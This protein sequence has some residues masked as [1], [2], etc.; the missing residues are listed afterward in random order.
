MDSL[1]LFR[2]LRLSI[3]FNAFNIRRRN[4]NTG[5]WFH[6]ELSIPAGKLYLLNSI[7]NQ[8]R[9]PNFHDSYLIMNKPSFR[10]HLLVPFLM[11]GLLTACQNSTEVSKESS[12]EAPI[13]SVSYG[14]GY[15][16]GQSIA[17]EG[18]D[19]FNYQN[20]IAGMQTAVDEEEPVMDETEMQETLQQFQVQLQQQQE[21]SRAEAAARN[22][23][24]SAA[25][26]EENGARDE[27]DVTESGLQYEV[28]EAGD[29]DTPEAQST[30]RVH[31]SGTLLNGEEFDS[32]YE[33]G[34]PVEFPLNRVI[35]GWTEGLQLMNEGATYRFWIPSEL[36]YGENPP[37]GSPIEPGSLLVFEIELISILD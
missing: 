12:F 10:R 3:L 35:P 17:S 8:S 18:I 19:D 16:Y 27:V 5:V 37:Q 25:F 22:S 9:N 21:Q 23:E 29:G 34:E 28:L 13:D 1:F 6:P 4:Q 20:F 31:Y 11:A 36:G 2:L 26:L 30:V 32:S 24:E 14:L 33:R 15:F 7:R